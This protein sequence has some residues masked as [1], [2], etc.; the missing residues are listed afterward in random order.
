MGRHS[1]TLDG[2]NLRHGLTKD[3]GFTAAD[4]VENVRRIAEVAKL[5]TDA[6]LV[7]LVR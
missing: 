5:F 3:L 4:R 7:V 6:G 2:D 1:Y